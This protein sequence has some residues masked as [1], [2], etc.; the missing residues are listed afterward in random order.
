MPKIGLKTKAA[1]TK[2]HLAFIKD[3]AKYFMDFLETDFHK[4]RNPKRSVKLRDNNNL[5]VGVN[6]N[7]YPAFCNVVWKA[8]GK[9][10]DENS[11]SKITK[12]VYRTNIPKNLL[13]LVNLQIK[14]IGQKKISAIVSYVADEIEKA[15]TLFKKEYD[16]ALVSSIESASS[17]I[18]KEIV[19]PFV[20]Q[21]EKPVENL[22]LADENTVYLMEEELTAVLVN[23]LESKISG[24]LNS[25]IAK[26]EIDLEK[27]LKTVFKIS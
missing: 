11:L 27:E 21:I 5:L 8:V 3:V 9:A 19:V 7:K 26:E 14:K 16:K 18:K 4:R 10:F 2:D 25:V 17:I 24:L 1:S 13:D 12:G 23:L 15:G 20:S 22:D 6:L